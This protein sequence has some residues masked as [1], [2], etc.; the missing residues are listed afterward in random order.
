MTQELIIKDLRSIEDIRAVEDLQ[1]TVWGMSDLDILPSTMLVAAVH[2]GGVLIGAFV[3]DYL[4]GFAFAFP[5]L[6]NGCLTMHSDMLGIDPAYRN[7]D[8]GYKLKL[9]Q[10][11][12]ALEFGIEQITWT[13]DPLQSVNAHFN[14]AKLGVVAKEYKPD[15]YGETSSFLHRLGTD[16]LWVRWLLKSDRVIER[17]TN[18]IAKED[19][20]SLVANC[21]SLI[22]VGPDMSPLQ[23]ECADLIEEN[24][25]IEIPANINAIASDNLELAMSWRAATRK[26]FTT[27]LS[28]GY[29]VEDFLRVE[30]D[31]RATGVYLLNREKT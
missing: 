23:S 24:L 22:K 18:R 10:R 4:A 2:V 14:F 15:F 11:D 20:A 26:A 7:L 19:I 17:L 9:A 21:G 12:R 30:N 5:G 16:R 13:F 6:E 25:T 27:A 29:V 8:L 31:G 1:R 28:S 3:D